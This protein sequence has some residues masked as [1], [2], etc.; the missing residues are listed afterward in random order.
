[1][2]RVNKQLACKSTG[3]WLIAVLADQFSRLVVMAKCHWLKWRNR[4]VAKWLGGYCMAEN[5][6][7]P[8][9]TNAILPLHML[10][11][12][13][14]HYYHYSHM[15]TILAIKTSRLAEWTFS[16]PT[17]NT[18]QIDR[19]LLLYASSTTIYQNIYYQIYFCIYSL[20][21]AGNGMMSM[22]VSKG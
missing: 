6:S 15:T 9:Y 4:W 11:T 5:S 20:V 16:R 22:G 8:K 13:N 2:G 3:G 1:M 18:G 14:H 10:P 12:T 7:A 17:A 19:E 21:T